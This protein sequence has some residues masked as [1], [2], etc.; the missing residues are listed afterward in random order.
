MPWK[1]RGV[2]FQV[3]PLFSPKVRLVSVES[4]GCQ[5]LQEIDPTIKTAWSGSYP[6]LPAAL[7]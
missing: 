4:T 5:S 6:A 2:T 7:S 1:E 3:K